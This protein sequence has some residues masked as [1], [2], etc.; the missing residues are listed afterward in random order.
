MSTFE[1]GRRDRQKKAERN[2]ERRLR[3]IIRLP[4]V[5][6]VTGKKRSAISFAA[7][8]T[9]LQNSSNMDLRSFVRSP[10]SS[11][12]AREARRYTVWP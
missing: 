11:K 12:A 9:R 8:F 1:V 2:D 7:G 6:A 10:C 3:R 4:E 5:E